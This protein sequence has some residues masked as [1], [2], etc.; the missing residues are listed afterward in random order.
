MD[1]GGGWLTQETERADDLGSVDAETLQDGVDQ[2]VEG[3]G[4][5]AAA[6]QRRQTLGLVLGFA[7]SGGLELAG[8]DGVHELVL[9]RLLVGGGG[10]G[11][12]GAGGGEEG[13]GGGEL[14]CV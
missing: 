13:Q 14:H 7:G 2:G 8:V 1:W 4:Q 12:H 5:G 11:D 6:E 3:S 10:R 9:Q